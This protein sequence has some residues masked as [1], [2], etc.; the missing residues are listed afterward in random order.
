MKLM[1][2]RVYGLKV[3]PAAALL[4][5]ATSMTVYAPS[6]AA[7]GNAGAWAAGGL[8]AGHMLTRMHMRREA[9]VYS[10]GE[11]QGAYAAAPA[12]AAAAPSTTTTL[13][14][15]LNQLNKLAAG[16]YITPAEYKAKKQALLNSL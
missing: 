15:K 14:Q 11:M 12:P 8:L 13:E 10:A 9:A 6:A 3:L 2:H 16:G 7:H 4:A 5:L 1:Q